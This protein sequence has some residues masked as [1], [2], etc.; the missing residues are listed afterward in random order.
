LR[1]Q[2]I[3]VCFWRLRRAWR[4]E[5]AVNLAAR[6]DFLRRDLAEQEA[7]C[8]ERDKEEEAIVLQLQSAQKEIENPGEISQELK[9][10]ILGLVPEFDALWSMFRLGAQ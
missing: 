2:R 7:Y 4:Y 10:R 1:F 3:A 5:N 9:Q 8:K 6:R